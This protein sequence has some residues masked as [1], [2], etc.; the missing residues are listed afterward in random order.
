MWESLCIIFGRGTVC[1]IPEFLVKR[2]ITWYLQL[3]QDKM[4]NLTVFSLIGISSPHSNIPNALCRVFDGTTHASASAGGQFLTVGL[5][6]LHNPFL[7]QAVNPDAILYIVVYMRQSGSETLFK[8][9]VQ[10][11]LQ[12]LSKKLCWSVLYKCSFDIRNEV[13]SWWDILKMSLSLDFGYL[14]IRAS[15][16]VTTVASVTLSRLQNIN[17]SP[18]LCIG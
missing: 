16:R 12:H 14:A 10:S 17:A 3:P 6:T 7:F 15:A 11:V 1:P 18:P 8:K 4:G 9:E 13:I 2:N 5:E